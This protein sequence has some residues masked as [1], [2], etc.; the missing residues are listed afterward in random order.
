MKVRGKI[1][2]LSR[3]TCR[4][5]LVRIALVVPGSNIQEEFKVDQE[6]MHPIMVMI[7]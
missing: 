2:V 5:K 4:K 6:H 3:V 7:D 1:I